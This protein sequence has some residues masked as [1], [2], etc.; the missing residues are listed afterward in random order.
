MSHNCIFQVW[1]EH[2]TGYCSKM[3]TNQEKQYELAIENFSFM[4][5]H[6]RAL[7][8]FCNQTKADTR[9]QCML[10]CSNFC[11]WW[12]ER[13]YVEYLSLFNIY[14]QYREIL[15]VHFSKL[16]NCS[17]KRSFWRPSSPLPPPISCRRELRQHP[18]ACLSQISVNHHSAWSSPFPCHLQQACFSLIL[19]CYWRS[20]AKFRKMC[21]EHWFCFQAV[22][23][24]FENSIIM[25]SCN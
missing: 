15:P 10:K 3:V 23:S 6:T 13:N 9:L 24:A 1:K 20:V 19:S 25:N 12:E 18:C 17:L 7:S 14:C 5:F 16:L 11:K 8:I 22:T 2:K 21:E 4:T